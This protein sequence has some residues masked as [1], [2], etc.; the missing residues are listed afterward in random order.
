MAHFLHAPDLVVRCGENTSCLSWD[1]TILKQVTEQSYA[2]ER[3]RHPQ[4]RG[5]VLSTSRRGHK[6]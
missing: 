6:G 3:S 2:L 5:T 4:R 1:A